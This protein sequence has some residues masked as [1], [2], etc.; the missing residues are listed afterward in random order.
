LKQRSVTVVHASG[1]VKETS[2]EDLSKR[3][4]DAFFKNGNLKCQGHTFSPEKVWYENVSLA[5]LE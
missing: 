4:R 1:E 5:K 2:L 3:H